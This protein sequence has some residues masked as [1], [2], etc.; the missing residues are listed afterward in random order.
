MILIYRYID[1]F[2]YYIDFLWLIW[3]G[4]LQFC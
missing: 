2:L 4:F 1:V 3:V